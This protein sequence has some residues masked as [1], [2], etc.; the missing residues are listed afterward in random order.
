MATALQ[1]E[2]IWNGL[3]D[4]NG[5]PL[6]AGRVYTYSAGTSTPISL[7]TSSDKSTFATNPLILDGNGKAQ[8]WG[9]GRYKFVVKSSADVT[10]YTLDNLLYGFDD[11]TVLLG[12][13]STGSANAQTVSVPST[14]ESYSNGQRVTFIAGYTNTGATTLQFNSLSAISIVKGPTTS[15]LQA[16]DIIAGQLYSCTYY[17]GQ[18]RLENFPT[19]ADIQRS[20]S[21]LLATVTGTNTITAN[22][23]PA[24]TGYEV[25]EVF[26]F[27]AANSNTAAATI[28]I[29]SLG[30]KAIQ[31]NN[32]ALTSGEIGQNLWHEIVYDGTQFQ[33]L[34]S[35]LSASTR[36]IP[37][38]VGQVQDG[39]V[40]NGGTSTGSANAQ[41]VNLSPDLTAYVAGQRFIFKAGFTNTGAATLAVDS[42]GP[43][44]IQFNNAA[45]VSGEIGQNLWHEIVYDGTQ[46]QLMNPASSASTRALP[47]TVGQVQDGSIIYGGTSTGS[48]NAQAINIAPDITAYTS[49]QR[50]VFK[51]GFTNTGATT[52]AVD[53]I[54]PAVAIQRFGVA[55]VG[56][57][58]QLNDIVE[59]VYDGAQFQLRNSTPDPVFIDR[60]NSRLGIGTSSPATIFHAVATTPEARIRGQNPVLNLQNTSTATNAGGIVRFDHDQ[61][62]AK[63]LAEI[64][65]ELIDGNVATRAGN[66][67]IALSAQS[68]GNLT[69][70]VFLR[71]DGRM[72]FNTSS[73]NKT[74]NF[75]VQAADEG[76]EIKAT[77]RPNLYLQ[78]ST[79]GGYIRYDNQTNT[80][81]VANVIIVSNTGSGVYLASGANA[82]SSVSDQRLKKNIQSLDRGLD[83]ILALHPVRYDMLVDESN[84]S[85]RLGFI[86]QEI[87]PHIPE[88]VAGQESTTYGITITDLIPVLTKAIQELA[89]K[90]DAL[91]SR[92]AALES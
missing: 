5:Q 85:S 28:N 2:S 3:T 92:I 45:L 10:L 35:A 57:E 65:A 17:G 42:L 59:V 78:S 18:F 58:I 31:F 61:T 34:N 36:T 55:L 81:G 86:A 20:R 53:S 69:N 40:L 63:P 54:T 24:L 76:V 60:T 72:G 27:K 39:A 84:D 37:I 15:S 33:L 64:R 22:A 56:G 70:R 68:T 12:G 49:G 79:T 46:F 9:D 41:V 26:R 44:A 77:N 13:I 74:F 75:D 82:W 91:E 30:P 25:G 48:A 4:N 87:L 62:S 6:A 73:I 19:T 11:T 32:A 29:D 8:V 89:A 88:M 80:V 38:T 1:V 52:L 90:N 83:E 43:K 47:T 21:H 67:V 51:A 14:V 50:F 23:T 16:G 66:V 71:H 7:Y